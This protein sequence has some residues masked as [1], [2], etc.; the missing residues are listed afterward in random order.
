MSDA[1]ENFA[2]AKVM[3]FAGP[4]LIVLRRDHTPGIPWPGFLDFPGGARDGEESPEACALR[5]TREEIGLIVQVK[6]LQLAHLREVRGKRSWF[7]AAH[8][9]ASAVNDVVFGNEGDGWDAIP[10]M[11]F[12]EAKDAIPHFR[13]ILHAYLKKK[14][15]PAG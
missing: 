3:L 1:R 9:P 13:E 6:A 12:V 2:G 5:E 11:D 14:P 4:L 8:L 10:P 7:F 15:G